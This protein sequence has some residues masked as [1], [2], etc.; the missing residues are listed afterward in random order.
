MKA[1]YLVMWWQGIFAGHGDNLPVVI[2]QYSMEDC[3]K[4]MTHQKRS[5]TDWMYRNPQLGDMLHT[6]QGYF[7]V[8]VD[9]GESL[10]LEIENSQVIRF[11]CSPV[12]RF[13]G[14]LRQ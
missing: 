11:R 13:D 14:E 2:G 1:F 9:T 6:G 10:V 3:Y 12:D 4:T 7:W 8:W 5:F